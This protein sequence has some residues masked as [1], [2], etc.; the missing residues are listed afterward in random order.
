[1]LFL[2]FILWKVVT[3]SFPANFSTIIKTK[4]TRLQK[5]DYKTLMGLLAYFNNSF[6]LFLLFILWKVVTYSFPKNFS[7]I[8]KTKST[9]LQK[10]DYKTLMG[11][12]V[13]L[14]CCAKLQLC[15]CVYK[16][17]SDCVFCPVLSL[18]MALTLS[19]PYI[20]GGPP[21]CV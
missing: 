8:I 4:S 18:A 20:Q 12:L 1:M 10:Q 7:T 11:L 2:C 6:I 9:R 14:L 15:T 21:L 5:Q 13:S 16:S 3:Y 17:S 19:W